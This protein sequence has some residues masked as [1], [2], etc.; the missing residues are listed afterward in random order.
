MFKR[1]SLIGVGF[2]L[3]LSGMNAY[4]DYPVA[5]VTNNTAYS[6]RGTVKYASAFCKN[7]SYSVAPGKTWRAKSR[8]VCLITGITG[9]ASGRAKHG[10]NTSITPY[11]STGTSYGQ[12]EINAYGDRYRIFSDHEFKSVS[13]TKGGKSPG[14]RLVN[15]TGWP[16]AYSLEQVG[17]LYHDVLPSSWQGRDG[18]R[19]V[20]TGAVWFTLR[21]HIQPDGINPQTDWDCVEPVAEIV[22]D[23][24]LAVAETVVTGGAGAPAAGAKIVAKQV[25]K[26]ALK[27]AV[28]VSA[29]G[30][31]SAM[32][33]KVG[34]YL[35]D[36]GSVTMAGQYA[37]YEWPFR[38]DKMPE[39]HITGG[40]GM[41]RDEN[42][43]IY[44][45]PGPTFTVTK[46]NGCGN[47]MMLASPK[48]STAKP[49]LKFPT[50]AS[51]PSG[52]G[53]PVVAPPRPAGGNGVTVYQHCN[54]GGY[55]VTLAPGRYNLQQLMARGIK[56]DDLSSIRVKS[57][58]NVTAYQHDNFQGKAWNFKSDDSCFVN[59][60]LNDVVSS[61]IIAAAPTGNQEQA[62][63]NM[64]QGKVAWNQAGN[65]KWGPN[66]IKNL[67]KGS[68]NPSQTIS[69]FK[70]GIARHNNWGQA[71]SS[72]AGK[73]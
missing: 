22:G 72:C 5:K 20:N 28:K 60:G 59:K 35:T 11:S 71:I 2:V 43:D 45:I 58:M 57:G 42:R 30:L 6:V 16:V 13:R 63:F 27:E 26:A 55:A 50:Q 34:Q 18:V 49:N 19:V 33:D 44:L 8:G 69:C 70:Q 62:C 7:D 17:C 41:A 53:N 12:F 39:Y 4:A 24:L 68:R 52:G 36:A 73:F 32:V 38:C 40:P 61:I 51:A 65:T 21:V 37:G 31:A 29:K 9:T 14:F 15:K 1:I 66:N 23:V 48:R 3:A 47:D 64:V 67:C 46:V 54:Y 25:A 56:N 10:E